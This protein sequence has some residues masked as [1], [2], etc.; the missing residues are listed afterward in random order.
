M[1]QA[2]RDPPLE[3][4]WKRFAQYDHNAVRQQTNFNKLL[5]WLLALGVLGTLLAVTR[6]QLELIASERQLQWAAELDL[7]IR[8]LHYPVLVAPIAVSVLLAAANRLKPGKKWVLL[9]GSAE[10]IKREI[11]SYRARAGAYCAD[12]QPGQPAR[13][14][15]L[16]KRVEEISQ[17]LMQTEINM[18]A[19]RPYTGPIPPLDLGGGAD[20]DD[21]LSTLSPDQYISC[22]INNQLDYFTNKVIRLERRL[23]Q[24]Q[25]AIYIAGGVGTLLAAIG[26]DLWVALTVTV[27]GVLASYIGMHNIE[28]SL[29]VYNQALTDLQ[30]VHDWWT[31]L[32]DA[33]RAEP[34]NV[35]KLVSYSEKILEGELA[36]WVQ[37]M[38]DALAELRDPQKAACSGD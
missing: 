6:T 2:E 7:L 31:A 9:R 11:Y 13:E 15:L 16:A 17:R 1:E 14:A 28:D 37:H 4:A 19:L 27:S 25:W 20:K 10:A 18:T 38:Q 12:D 30:N 33:E 29:V 26:Q 35:D 8:V 5:L 21:G 24:T 36:G 22:R 3:Q 23:H 34:G 32:S